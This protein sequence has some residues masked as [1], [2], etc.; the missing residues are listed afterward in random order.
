MNFNHQYML[1]SI[2]GP[3]LS[4]S[5]ALMSKKKQ[6]EILESDTIS[7][8][9][10]ALLVDH[11]FRN[12]DRDDYSNDRPFSIDIPRDWDLPK[13]DQ[14]W[15]LLHKH[16]I[17]RGI[18]NGALDFSNFIFPPFQWHKYGN[19]IQHPQDIWIDAD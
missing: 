11:Y 4:I 7:D 19:E 6:K 10:Y 12:K 9:D 18:E 16:T 8:E 5:D 15:E 1:E 2:S 3:F 14:F 13:V 17:P